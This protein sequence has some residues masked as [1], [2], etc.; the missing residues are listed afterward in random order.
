M[1]GVQRASWRGFIIH[2]CPK[3]AEIERRRTKGN[4]R[5]HEAPLGG[6]PKVASGIVG[7]MAYVDHVSALDLT[8]TQTDG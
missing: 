3:E 8:F 7:R 4:N 5:G 1:G 2:A 6:I